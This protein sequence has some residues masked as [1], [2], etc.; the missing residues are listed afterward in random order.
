MAWVAVH[1]LGDQAP[2]AAVSQA[3]YALAHDVE[4][5]SA[6]SVIEELLDLEKASL[7]DMHEKLRH[8]VN[9]GS[10]V[11]LETA[12]VP[13]P[14]LKSFD[15][16]FIGPLIKLK[17]GRAKQ[18]LVA[19]LLDQL[20]L[21]SS[22][23]AIQRLVSCLMA[24]T[25]PSAFAE[26]TVRQEVERDNPDALGVLR[27]LA[28]EP[29]FDHLWHWIGRQEDT[30]EQRQQKRLKPFQLGRGQ[31]SDFEWDSKGLPLTTRAD[32]QRF[33]DAPLPAHWSTGKWMPDLTG[34]D[35]EDWIGQQVNEDTCAPVI[36]D[37]ASR[38]EDVQR[39]A[40]MRL[41]L[42]WQA[43]LAIKWGAKL[44]GYQR[45]INKA[46]LIE[47]L[48][49]ACAVASH[50]PTTFR[51]AGF[52]SKCL[53]PTGSLHDEVGQYM[54]DYLELLR[55][56]DE[57]ESVRT[58]ILNL[59]AM[60]PEHW[61]VTLPHVAAVFHSAA[62]S[63]SLR[64]TALSTFSFIA[65]SHEEREQVRQA[66]AELSS[67]LP[68]L[69]GVVSLRDVAASALA[70]SQVGKHNGYDWEGLPE[71]LR[72]LMERKA[73]ACA[74][75]NEPY[76]HLQ[77]SAALGMC[78]LLLRAHGVVGSDTAVSGKQAAPIE[79]SVVM[80]ELELELSAWLPSIK[81]V[82]HAGLA[83]GCSGADLG[84]TYLRLLFGRD[85]LDELVALL[86][87][88]LRE[89]GE[90]LTPVRAMEM[91]REIVEQCF[92][93]HTPA[94][95]TPIGVVHGVRPVPLTEERAEILRIFVRMMAQR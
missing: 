76:R 86:L 7:S 13:W 73:W 52:D 5:L 43:K 92:M 1:H 65:C 49:I 62:E 58:P 45:V 69:H 63:L 35:D 11:S 14:S 48:L 34:L 68:P 20:G 44:I 29:Q 12:T 51:V 46:L 57:P 64:A 72:G 50:T 53:P 39:M 91:A 32:L 40:T 47:R 41:V 81:S 30:E 16:F 78:R 23:R 8:E 70:S 4:F 84:R 71:E 61:S 22:D 18:L 54:R 17:S 94:P 88:A 42:Q 89:G 24:V 93:D 87:V 25:L 31:S 19:C 10:R 26:G 59:I 85:A 75:N 15:E 56:V 60:F 36:R 82:L 95:P 2:D 77:M 74:E 38:C 21:S 9:I 6:W 3:V 28:D 80:S 83:E 90:D 66:I 55:D 33:F 37:L 27:R 79:W 67:F